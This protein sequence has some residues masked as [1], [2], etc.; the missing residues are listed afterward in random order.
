MYTTLRQVEAYPMF[1]SGLPSFHSERAVIHV[2][3]LLFGVSY[4]VAEV[5]VILILDIKYSVE[6]ASLIYGIL[7]IRY[8]SYI[9]LIY[10]DFRH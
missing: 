1:V 4:Y 5:L 9:C 6:F 10:V 7:I 3:V 2:S 8:I